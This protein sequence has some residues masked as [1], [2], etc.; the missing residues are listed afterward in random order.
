M[1]DLNWYS[2]LLPQTFDFPRSA[3]VLDVGCGNGMQLEQASGRIKIGIDPDVGSAMQCKGKGFP[4]V[5]G[6]AEQLPF[7]DNSIDGIICKVVLCLT[8][9]DSAL[10][11]I[12]RVLKPGGKAYIIVNGVGYYLRYLLIAWS[13]RYRIFGLRALINTWL[14]SR[15]RLRLWWFWG[16]TIY[17]SS[18]RL[19]QYCSRLNLKIVSERQSTFA[20]L[21]VF[22]Y[23]ELEAL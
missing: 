22:I 11:E 14:W 2:F 7:A 1:A 12:A 10:E 5:I 16:D 13:I 8:D 19:H 23:T 4:V 20:G 21:P 17:Q 15:T 18:G 3:T 6:N 9:E